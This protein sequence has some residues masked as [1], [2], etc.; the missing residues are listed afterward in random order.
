MGLKLN[1]FEITE[2]KLFNPSEAVPP[3]LDN[4]R[5]VPNGIQVANLSELLAFKNDSKLAVLY[6]YYI[7]NWPH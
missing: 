7:W 5:P 4:I 6:D 1:K 2:V 3:T